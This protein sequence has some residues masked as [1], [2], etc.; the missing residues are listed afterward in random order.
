MPVFEIVF[1]YWVCKGVCVELVLFSILRWVLGIKIQVFRLT[2]KV[3]CLL[4][5]L[6]SSGCQFYVASYDSWGTVALSALS[7]Q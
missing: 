7:D 1:Y 5:H 2:L 3:L 4:S 6:L